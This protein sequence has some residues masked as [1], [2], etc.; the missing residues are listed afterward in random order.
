VNVDLNTEESWEKL[1]IYFRTLV[2][3]SGTLSWNIFLICREC[4]TYDPVSMDM[5]YE[6]TLKKS[7]SFSK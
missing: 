4:E 3:I 2:D 7:D 6:T 1:Q 5:T